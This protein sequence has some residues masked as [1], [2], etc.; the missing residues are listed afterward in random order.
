LSEL[1]YAELLRELFPRLT[2]G[3]RWG[4]ERT[5][6]LLAAVGN[7]HESF[8]SMH[9][10]GTNGKGS[11]AA[12]LAAILHAD[13]RHTGLYSSP[14]LCTFRERVQ[15]DGVAI[16]EAEILNAATRLWPEIGRLTPSFFEATTAIAFL[17]LAE[18][19]VDSAVIEVGLGGRL[20]ATNV[21]KPELAV[22]TNIALDHAEYLGNTLESVAREKAG[23]IKSGVA[24]LTAE[25]HPVPLAIF[26][27]R[28]AELGAP[29]Y[30]LLPH[31]ISNATYDLNG[32][33]F[34]V[35]TS[36][37]GN[38]ELSSPLIGL[39]QATN[40]ALAVR[41]ADALPLALRPS[42]EAVATGV[43]NVR[44][45]GRL[46]VEQI[47]AQ[48]WLFDG[49]HNVAGVLALVAAVRGLEVARPLV[50]VIGILGDKDWQAMLPALFE[51]ADLAVL[52]VPPTAPANRAWQPERVLEEIGSERAEVVRDF[53]AALERAR[54]RAAAG[55]VL[56]TGSFHTVGDALI[57]LD[58]APFGSDA[59]LPLLAIS[60]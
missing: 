39:H 5:L 32:T 27:Q 13:G 60:G 11:V 7:P 48:R 28:A 56:V 17:A 31:E 2:G 38:L 14:H 30:R 22:I 24:L 34:T 6:A 58:R 57:A 47:G 3:I 42:A 29:V 41:A 59:T 35:P 55:T 43:S 4:L 49:A 26:S 1:T 50:V 18:A 19:G 53:T 10:G 25:T 21:I 46:Q 51:L 15:V 40:A 44:W 36:H 23:I 37:Y 16:S 20:D 52:T 45:P 8:R 9:V 54:G 33:Q 12:T